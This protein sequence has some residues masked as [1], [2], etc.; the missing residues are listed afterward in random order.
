MHSGKPSHARADNSL[1]RLPFL[2]K[3]AIV[4]ALMCALASGNASAIFGVGDVVIDPTAIAKQVAEFAEQA[5]RWEATARQYKQ[6]LISLGGLSFNPAKLSSEKDSLPYVD[7][8]YG[9]EDACRKKSGDGPLG[10]ISNLFKPDSN[11]EILDQQLEICKRIV[12]AE[13]LKYNETVRFLRNLR[14]RQDELKTLDDRRASVGSEQ[15]K[16]QALSYDIERYH[17]NTK[18]DLDNW[19]AMIVAYDSYIAQLNKYQQR[20]ANRALNGKQ[21]D[22]LSGVVQGLVLKKVLDERK[23]AN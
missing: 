5:K 1:K 16:L 10:V 20:L 15:G 17:Q 19:Q 9:L 13:N 18:M 8:E 4:G 11:Q 7:P 21:P 6:Q 3:T 23:N 12:R 2:K 22:M 14:D